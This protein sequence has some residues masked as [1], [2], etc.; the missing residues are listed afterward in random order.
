[1]NASNQ[2]RNGC[3]G[4]KVNGLATKKESHNHKTCSKCPP[5][6][7]Q[8]LYSSSSLCIQLPGNESIMFVHKLLFTNAKC[9]ISLHTQCAQA[10]TH[11]LLV[12]EETV[13]C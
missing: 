8:V 7:K 9:S 13:Y 4:M 10:H 12:R 1:M 2:I 11:Y 6:N 5:Q 3:M